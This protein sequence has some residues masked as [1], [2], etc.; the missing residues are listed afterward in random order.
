MPAGKEEGG[1]VGKGRRHSRILRVASV[2]LSFCG[3]PWFGQLDRPFRPPKV[4]RGQHSDEPNKSKGGCEGLPSSVFQ[5]GM[6]GHEL[7]A[8]HTAGQ[9]Q[10]RHAGRQ[11]LRARG[12]DVRCAPELLILADVES[13]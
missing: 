13:W 6:P 11:A 5:T 2:S 8:C 10:A 7:R 9:L 12:V 4:H 3:S 1:E